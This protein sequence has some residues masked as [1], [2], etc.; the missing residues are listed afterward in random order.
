MRHSRRSSVDLI[1]RSNSVQENSRS[2]AGG[3]QEPNNIR[4]LWRN[5]LGNVALAGATLRMHCIQFPLSY[6]HASQ[7]QALLDRLSI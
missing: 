1:L 7:L 5:H 3:V 4:A 6:H 2:E